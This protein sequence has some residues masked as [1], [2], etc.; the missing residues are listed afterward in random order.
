MEGRR[1]VMGALAGGIAGGLGLPLAYLLLAPVP[2]EPEAWSPVPHDAGAWSSAG[3]LSGRL[4]R[5]ELPDGHGPEDIEVDEAGRVYM[6]LHDGRILRT[7]A[8]GA[9]EAE[10]FADTGGRPL[11]LHWDA[12][13]R[14]LVADAWKGLL[15][16][17]EAGA[18]EVLTTTC[19]GRELIF[20]D[21]LE[22]TTD[23]RIWFSDA[24][25]RYRQPEWKLDII[26]NR[27]SGRLCVYD[28]QT[29]ETMEWLDGLYFGNGVAIDIDEQY[30]LV[31]ETSRYR[32]RKVF[33]DGP[34]LGEDEILIDDLPGFPDG[35][36]A[37][38]DGIYWLAI[39]SPRNPLIDGAGPSPWLRKL[40]V[41]LPESV[42]PAPLLT[43]RVVGIDGEGEVRVDLFDPSGEDMAVVTSIQ[44]RDG[45]LYLGSLVDTA[46]AWMDRP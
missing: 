45:R 1:L 3:E 23:G 32:V 26:E 4:H 33:I 44:E 15:R 38:S 29:G 30:L 35:I 10:V 5:I 31:N 12:E 13:G 21:D 42:Q 20:T 37:G 25:V 17:D 28:P 41:R 6:G 2:V 9:G 40:M 18:I 39:A 34:R 8:L 14:L 46:W 27:G 16:I 22:T 24:T 7:P 19:G 43:A 36:S 11:G